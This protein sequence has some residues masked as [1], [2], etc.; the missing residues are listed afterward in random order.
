VLS[1]LF[2]IG[3]AI[4]TVVVPLAWYARFARFNLF[5]SGL[6]GACWFFF[7][8]A[9]RGRPLA[10]WERAV[11]GVA[12]VTALA[13]LVPDVT[14]SGHVVA[15]EVSWLALTYRDVMPTRLGGAVSVYYVVALAVLGVRTLRDPGPGG[16]GAGRRAALPHRDGPARHAGV[17]LRAAR[18]L[19][20]VRHV[21][22]GQH[23]HPAARHRGPRHVAAEPFERVAVVRRRAHARVQVEPVELSDEPARRQPPR[24]RRTRLVVASRSGAPLVDPREGPASARRA[25]QPLQAVVTAVPLRGHGTPRTAPLDDLQPTTRATTLRRSSLVGAAVATNTGVLPSSRHTN[26]PS[27]TST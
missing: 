16:A 8:A 22:V 5:L 18:R 7:D 3:D 14:V 9:Q 27:A 17:L 4:T 15:R 25:A 2:T 21:A 13:S 12:L 19:H 20:P 24:A 6:H 26:T 10:R 23:A 11:V 1:A